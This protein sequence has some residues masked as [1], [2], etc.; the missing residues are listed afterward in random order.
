[1]RNRKVHAMRRIVTLLG[2]FGIAATFVGADPPRS[3]AQFGGGFR[4]LK[5]SERPPPS[6][7]TIRPSARH[8]CSH[9]PALIRRLPTRR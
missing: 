2:I 4:A 6:K 8:C 3:L 1:M 5:D 9:N 7:S